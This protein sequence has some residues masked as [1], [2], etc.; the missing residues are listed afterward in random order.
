MGKQKEVIFTAKKGEQ[1]ETAI[2]DVSDSKWADGFS[3]C[4]AGF[5]GGELTMVI[6]FH[7]F[8][9]QSLSSI[10]NFL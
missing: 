9:F 5:S 3:F 8:F 1:V 2:F 7:S 4:I 6:V 10:F